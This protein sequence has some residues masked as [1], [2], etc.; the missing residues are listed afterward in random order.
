[1]ASKGF[2]FHVSYGYKLVI[3]TKTPI[4]K[5]WNKFSIAKNKFGCCLFS[6]QITAIILIIWNN[7]AVKY[8]VKLKF[9]SDN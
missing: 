2:L 7:L 4:I 8:F 1:M 5:A 6:R 3:I 9:I